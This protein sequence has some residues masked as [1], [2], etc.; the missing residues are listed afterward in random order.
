[1]RRDENVRA[2]RAP[3]LSLHHACVVCAVADSH[4]RGVIDEVRY[5]LPIM[6]IGRSKSY[7]AQLPL[8]IDGNVQFEAIVPDLPVLAKLGYASGYPMTIGSNKLTDVQHG[9]VHESQRCIFG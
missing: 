2:V 4:S 9:T 5:L 7:G 6:L 8:G 3:H 1:M